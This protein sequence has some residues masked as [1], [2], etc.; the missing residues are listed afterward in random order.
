MSENMR[1]PPLSLEHIACN[2][3]DPAAMAAWYVAHLGMRLLRQSPSPP[4]IH[5]LADAAGR[6]VLELY[7][8]AGDRIPDYRSMNPIQFHIAFATTDPEGVQAALA[9]VGATLVDD[10]TTPDGSRLLMLRDPWGMPLQLC[11][12]PTALLD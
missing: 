3:E 9:A 6:T 2:V 10:R 7:R 12:R 5:F 11:K 1:M 4:H 8:N